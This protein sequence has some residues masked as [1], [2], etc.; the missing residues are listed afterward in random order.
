MASEKTFTN[1]YLVS[2]YHLPSEVKKHIT[3]SGYVMTQNS[4]KTADKVVDGY[5]TK[6]RFEDAVF[7]KDGEAPINYSRRTEFMEEVSCYEVDRGAL[8]VQFEVRV[9]ISAT[10]EGHE[11]LLTIMEPYAL[12]KVQ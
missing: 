12:E 3:D 4:K 9:K 2:G 10:E 6:T 5:D 7:M 8:T 11:S 1:E